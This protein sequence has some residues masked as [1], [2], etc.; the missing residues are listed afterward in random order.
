[1][2]N[3]YKKRLEDIIQKYH[4]H[5]ADVIDSTYVNSLIAAFFDI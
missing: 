4:M 2:E 5:C 1:M 3:S